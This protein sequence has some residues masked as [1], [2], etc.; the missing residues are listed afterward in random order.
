MR[1]WEVEQNLMVG[2]YI[3]IKCISLS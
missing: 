3:R 1:M 2:S